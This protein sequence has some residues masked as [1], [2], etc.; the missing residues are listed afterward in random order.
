M[1]GYQRLWRTL[2]LLVRVDIAMSIAIAF[3][4]LIMLAGR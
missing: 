3:A 2:T 4:L 1:T